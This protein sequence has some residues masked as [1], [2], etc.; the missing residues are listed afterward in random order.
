MLRTPKC[1][2]CRNHGF[3]V[4]VKG[5][6]GKCRWKQCTCE[7]CYLIAERQKIMAAQKV[8][9][10]QAP[11]E[12]QE[13]ALGAQGPQLA[14]GSAAANPGPRF[15]PLPPLAVL[16]DA[17]PGPSGQAAACFPERPPRG[18][19][20]G[21]SAFQPILGGRNCGHMGL[22]EHAAR[23][24][25]SSLEPQ[26]AAEAT[27]R[28]Y[29][30][31]LELRRPPRPVPSPLFAD[32]GLPL[33][34][35]SDSVVRSEYLE[36]EPPKLY[37]GCS[38]MHPY[39]PFPL[40][41]QGASPAA[42]PPLQQGFGHVSYGHYNGGGLGAYWPLCKPSRYM[43]FPHSVWSSPLHILLF[44]PWGPVSSHGPEVGPQVDFQPSY[45]PPL[46][47]SQQP[48]FLPPG[49]LSALHFFPP[50]PPPPPPPSPPASFSLTILSD[51]DKENTDDQDMEGPIEPSQPSSQEQSD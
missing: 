24:R 32:F 10:K 26:L 21:T 43:L 36:R 12:E 47:P 48:Q 28:G 51:T 15:Y 13:V 6:A 37:P 23:A 30:G 2:R 17:Q 39:G 44:R 4:P 25:P 5:H 8:L 7:K 40:G 16:G 18:W 34:I 14:S 33:S 46:A 35:N 19:S 49:F 42:G 45:Y 3:L 38:S 31:C 29:P 11:G 1:S 50:P 22:S 27:G 20:P 9:K 41:Y